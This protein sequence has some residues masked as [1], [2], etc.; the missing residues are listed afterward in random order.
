MHLRAQ[1][2]AGYQLAA[3]RLPGISE[4]T[5]RRGLP[6]GCGSSSWH[7][8]T[9]TRESPCRRCHGNG[10]GMG[11][12]VRRGQSIFRDLSTA[13]RYKRLAAGGP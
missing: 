1:R 13:A 11:L 4:S 6:T 10:G 2:A 5:E 3:A 9:V 8:A 7:C 12:G